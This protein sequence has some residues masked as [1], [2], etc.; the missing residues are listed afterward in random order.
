MA[1]IYMHM[2]KRYLLLLLVVLNLA[3]VKAQ[4]Q[5]RTVYSFLN[6]T[7]SAR[8]AALGSRVIAIDDND[9]NLAFHN[10]SLLNQEMKNMLTL[11]HV[12][13]HAGINHGYAAYA[14]SFKNAGNFSLGV[15]FIDYGSFD[16]T[17]ELYND[18]GTFQAS[19]YAIHMSYSRAFNERFNYGV[20]LKPVFS[21][22]EQYNSFGLL[23]DMGITMT[24]ED[25]LLTSSVVVRNLGAQVTS[26]YDGAQKEEVPLDVLFGISKKFE[27]APFRLMFTL[28]DLHKWDLIYESALV[29][30]LR[31]T[32]E[33]ESSESKISELS[34]E[35]L[36]H[37]ILSV[38]M[39]PLKNFYLRG[40][41]DYKRRMELKSTSAPKMVGFSFGLGLK[42]SKFHISYGR[43]IYHTNGGSNHFTISTNLTDFGKDSML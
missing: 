1:Y 11:N 32:D 34:D 8:S 20:S 21:N 7:P 2:I 24:T 22:L 27:H 19:E 26:Y 4:E 25:K 28:H 33:T 41:F 31:H 39:T 15:Q 14:Q 13:Y 6:L 17:D 43:M 36:R 16:H 5:G 3:S 10:P 30:E 38:E 40:G 18:Y 12:F 37:V 35:F 9:L 42:I 29:N 23:L